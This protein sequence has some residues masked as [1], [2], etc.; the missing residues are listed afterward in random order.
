MKKSHLVVIIA[1]VL[2]LLTVTGVVFFL[3]RSGNKTPVSK[4]E[5]RPE[6]KT[7]VKQVDFQFSNAAPSTI[8]TKAIISPSNNPTGTADNEGRSVVVTPPGL[9]LLTPTSTAI[10][11]DTPTHKAASITPVATVTKAS[12]SLPK[13][14]FIENNAS[15]YRRST[16]YPTTRSCAVRAKILINRSGSLEAPPTR[17]PSAPDFNS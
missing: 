2:V 5:I 15:G 7:Y 14:G 3:S 9:E 13:A 4:I 10:A 16:P 6:R 8:P 1:L 11:T 17:K 12:A